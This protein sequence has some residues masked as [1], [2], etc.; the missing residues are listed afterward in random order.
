MG[1]TPEL[2]DHLLE[3]EDGPA[4]VA[5]LGTNGVDDLAELVTLKHGKAISYLERVV[6]EKALKKQ[7]SK[8]PPPQTKVNGTRKP[9]VSTTDN[10]WTLR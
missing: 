6:R 8:A 10:G 2:T 9:S 5:Y 7:V 1:I 3:D 4:L